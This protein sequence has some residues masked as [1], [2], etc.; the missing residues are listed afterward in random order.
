MGHGKGVEMIDT[1]PGSHLGELFVMAHNGDDDDVLLQVL[2]CIL[3]ECNF[4]RLI[5]MWKTSVIDM[6]NV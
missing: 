4:S 5:E 3:P 2:V 1:E 6:A